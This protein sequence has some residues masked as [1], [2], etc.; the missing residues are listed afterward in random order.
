M[1][2]DSVSKIGNGT[3]RSQESAKSGRRGVVIVQPNG[4]NLYYEAKA[5]LSW[6]KQTGLTS[7]ELAMTGY[8]GT[9]TQPESW[10]CMGRDV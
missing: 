6:M 10:D 8:T 7:V 5:V 2:S 4:M 3:S 9:R 1:T